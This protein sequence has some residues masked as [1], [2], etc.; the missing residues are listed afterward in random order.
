MPYLAGAR[1]RASVPKKPNGTVLGKSLTTVVTVSGGEFASCYQ[2]SAIVLSTTSGFTSAGYDDTTNA[3]GEYKVWV[4]SVGTFD[5]SSTKTDNFKIRSGPSIVFPILCIDK[6]YDAN[7]DGIKNNGEVSITGWKFDITFGSS[8][9]VRYT[10]PTGTCTTLDE[11]TYQIFEANPI[12]TSWQHTTATHVEVTLAA[13][14]HI[15]VEFGNVCLGAGGGL[16]LGFWSN[17]N[18]QA[19]LTTGDFTA[20]TALHLRNANGT[21]RDFTSSLATNK[22]ALKNWLLNATATNMAYML[23]A[24][25][26]TM[27]LNVLHNFVSG[28]SLVYAYGCGNTG[29]GNNYI[30]ITDL[31]AAADA[32]LGADGS[33]PSG[34]EPNRT[35]QTCL[36]NALDDANNNRNF[37]EATPCAFSF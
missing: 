21:D 20:L 4:S 24:Q 14:D 2:L 13:G 35:T 10:G 23:S 28:S 5:N 19:L 17:K 12:A 33:T 37:V 15:T 8:D 16:T 7:V 26:A 31:I 3:G 6:F 25:L 27:K 30:T 34:D 1:G 22:T 29:A 36:K 32:A 9:L 18:G 11:G